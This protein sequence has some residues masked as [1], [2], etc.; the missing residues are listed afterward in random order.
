MDFSNTSKNNNTP[1]QNCQLR[2]MPGTGKLIFAVDCEAGD[3]GAI[4]MIRKKDSPKGTFK[5]GD[6]FYVKGSDTMGSLRERLEREHHT[7]LMGRP[8]TKD[9]GGLGE[10]MC[11]CFRI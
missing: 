3:Q 5:A 9:P 10:E 2:V 7:D 8:L 11:F 1:P 4:R 6:E